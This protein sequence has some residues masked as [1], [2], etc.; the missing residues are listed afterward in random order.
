M[1]VKSVQDACVGCGST[2][3]VLNIEGLCL[4]SDCLCNGTS[5]PELV[6]PEAP[7][8]P[9]NLLFQALGES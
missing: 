6:A 8:T 3:D 4:C 1:P 2:H 7:I 5:D 9:Y